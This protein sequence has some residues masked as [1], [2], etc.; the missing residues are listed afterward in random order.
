VVAFRLT[1]GYGDTRKLKSFI[2]CGFQKM[3]RVERVEF[4]L[5][6]KKPD[7]LNCQDKILFAQIPE[8]TLVTLS[9]PQVNVVCSRGIL[10]G[11]GG[12]LTILVRQIIIFDVANR[13]TDDPNGGRLEVPTSVTVLPLESVNFKLWSA[14]LGPQYNLDTNNAALFYSLPRGNFCTS[15][16]LSLDNWR[17]FHHFPFDINVVRPLKFNGAVIVVKRRNP[18]FRGPHIWQAVQFRINVLQRSPNICF[19]MV[20]PDIITRHQGICGG[21]FAPGSS[22]NNVKLEARK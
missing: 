16:D 21:L 14:K 7:I 1:V 15:R 19:V 10:R 5:R 17:N 3:N 8:P 13:G 11:S 20:L 12:R 6:T 22:L 4:R 2:L 18:Q 9:L